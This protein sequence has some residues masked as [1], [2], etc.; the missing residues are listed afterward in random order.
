MKFRANAVFSAMQF[1]YRV[2]II[3]HPSFGHLIPWLV[4][5]GSNECEKDV[6]IHKSLQPTSLGAS[7]KGGIV[8]LSHLPIQRVLKLLALP[9]LPFD[10]RLTKNLLKLLLF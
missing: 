1:V 2:H 3:N 7:R 5:E 10:P 4:F 9:Q 6:Q 8:S